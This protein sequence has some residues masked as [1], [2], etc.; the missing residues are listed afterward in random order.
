MS[1]DQPKSFDEMAL[2]HLDTVYRVAY[3]LARDEHFAED[4]V[5]ETYL[6]AYRA[7]EAFE[8]REFGI[9]P[10]LLRI[11]RNTFLNRASREQRAPKATEQSALEQAHGDSE[12]GNETA[13]PLLDFE[14]LDGEVK[15]AIE[16]LSDEF[17]EVILL[18]GTGELS[19]QDIAAVLE[20]PL[21][22]VMSRLHRARKQ[23]MNDLD[24]YAREQRLNIGSKTE[25]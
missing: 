23:L 2:P 15:Q 7:F 20:I 22:T 19:Y 11:L 8:L 18:W 12:L 6:K 4:L 5:Q 17:R 14:Q 3:R 1:T 10:W 9:R 13:P 16:R 21:G 25:S 24:E